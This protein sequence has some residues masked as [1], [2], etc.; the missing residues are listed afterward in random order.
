M[1]EL[2]L[3][4]TASVVP[5]REWLHAFPHAF[6]IISPLASLPRV[7]VA[8]LPFQKLRKHSIRDADKFAQ[9]NLHI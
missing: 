2:C 3:K 7:N 9:D 8:N 4:A 5:E 6:C 1:L